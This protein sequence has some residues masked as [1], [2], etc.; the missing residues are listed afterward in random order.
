MSFPSAV[1]CYKE[2]KRLL[3]GESLHPHKKQERKE[4]HM[5][6]PEKT[7]P[8]L[9][10]EDRE[11]LQ[12]KPAALAAFEERFATLDEEQ[13]EEIAGGGACCGRLQRT[14]SAPQLTTPHP[15]DWMQ[16][17]ENP[18]VRGGP[19]NYSPPPQTPIITVTQPG[20]NRPTGIANPRSK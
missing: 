3:M 11:T 2:E 12:E 13:L 8:L 15:Q 19:L 7:Q 14:R 6:D 5:N 10:Q 17:S 4:P 9:A 20:E 1:L 16:H 18:F